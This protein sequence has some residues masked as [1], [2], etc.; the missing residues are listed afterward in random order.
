MDRGLS[1]F[2]LIDRLRRQAA[3][4]GALVTGLGDDASVT[5][6]PGPTA[7][8]VDAVVEG[9]HFRREWSDPA[10]IAHKAVGAALSDLAAMAAEVGEVWLTT[11]E[12]VRLNFGYRI[13]KENGELTLEAE[14]H[15]VCMS[16]DEKIKRLP[17]ELVRLVGP[18]LRPGA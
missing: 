12:R 18:Y 1:E 7:T 11:A 4:T 3:T 6:D 13:T 8:S 14:T 15:H 17:S 10:L 5:Q 2:E 9:V 16:L